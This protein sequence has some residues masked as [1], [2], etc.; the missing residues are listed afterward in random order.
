MKCLYYLAPT[1][2]STHRI[3]DD[4][5]DVGVSDWFLHVVSHDEAGLKR[6][7]IHSSNYLET[8]DILRGGLI[9]ANLGFFAGVLGAALLM[10]FKPFGPDLP[11]YIYGIVVALATLFGSW[12]GGLVGVA[13]ENQKLKRFHDDLEAGKYLILIYARKE[14]EDTIKNMMRDRHQEARHVATDR[15]FINPFS[16]VRRKRRVAS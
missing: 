6:E 7:H 4:L 1:L 10:F 8:Q 3:S 9:G 12:Q 2:D 13:N 16:V 15:H 14:K 11:G 5:H